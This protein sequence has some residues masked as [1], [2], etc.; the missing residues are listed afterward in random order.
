MEEGGWVKR[1]VTSKALGFSF[2]GKR[3]YGD[4]GSDYV[5]GMLLATGQDC[6]S[7]FEWTFASG[8]KLTMNCVINLTTPAGGD[9]TNIDTFEFEVLSDGKPTFTPAA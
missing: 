9:T 1:A 4:P 6:E 8:A 3:I 5:A 2:S 7:V